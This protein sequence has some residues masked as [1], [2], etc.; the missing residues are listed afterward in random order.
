MKTCASRSR[1]GV[2]ASAVFEAGQHLGQPAGG[3]QRAE[4][5]RVERRVPFGEVDD[6]DARLGGK[7]A[8]GREKIDSVQSSGPRARGGGELRAVD[9]IGVTIDEDR[10]CVR[11]MLK[12]P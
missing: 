4:V 2:S 9:D 3:G 5:A 11:D 7:A 8:R 1:F 10:F 6:P 12:R